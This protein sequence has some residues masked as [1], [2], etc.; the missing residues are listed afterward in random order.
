MI[1]SMGAI[2][3]GPYFRIA[4][5]KNVPPPQGG[6]IQYTV[7]LNGGDAPVAAIERGRVPPL[8]PWFLRL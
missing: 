8:P 2:Y 1:S 4:A 6:K 3:C 7:F 5:S